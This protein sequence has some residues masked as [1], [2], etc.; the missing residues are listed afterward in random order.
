L[1]K[2]LTAR[3]APVLAAAIT[4]VSPG[5]KIAYFSKDAREGSGLI[6]LRAKTPTEIDGSDRF[7]RRY[8]T[9]FLR[10][11]VPRVL[12]DDVFTVRPLG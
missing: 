6:T 8:S 3:Y 10:V 4:A 5:E 12:D 2:T 9:H 7:L 1:R 11:I